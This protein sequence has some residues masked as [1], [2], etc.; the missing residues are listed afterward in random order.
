MRLL[1]ALFGCLLA[2][3]ALAQGPVSPSAPTLAGALNPQPATKPSSVPPP[4]A[5]KPSD[6]PPADASYTP[7]DGLTVTML[8][9]TSR[10]KLF[11]QFSAIGIASTDRPLSAGLP[12]LLLPGS[13]F[14]LSTN[15]FDLHARQSALGASFTGPEVCGFTPGAFFLGFIQNDNLLNDAYGL[16]PYQAYGELKNDRWRI[17]AGLQS[18]VFNPGK[19][20]IIS[21]GSLFGSGNTGSFRGQVRVEHF[22]KPSDDFQITTQAAISEPVS[23]IVSGNR[24]IL[25]DNGWPNV[26]VRVE[27]GIGGGPR[28]VRRPEATPGRGWHLRRGRPDTDDPVA[29]LADGP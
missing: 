22:L 7:G 15:T 1:L 28:S 3:P 5:P 10:L 27:A 6:G 20:T 8:N 17:A 11:A 4:A 23:T 16:L 21:L 25:E 9:G 12:L 29:P 24:R 18:D 2:I 26:E 13:P 14:G 19:P